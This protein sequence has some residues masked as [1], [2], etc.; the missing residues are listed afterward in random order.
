MHDSSQ[1]CLP[2]SSLASANDESLGV[3]NSG[4]A[5]T[6]VGAS[7]KRFGRDATETLP[8]VGSPAFYVFPSIP[9]PPLEQK[10]RRIEMRFS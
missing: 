5:A 10:S 9:L 2:M 7:A 8:R 4:D 6:A 1:D 3:S